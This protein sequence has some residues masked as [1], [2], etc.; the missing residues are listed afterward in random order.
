[1]E[2]VVTTKRRHIYPPSKPGTPCT[3]FWVGP[4]AVLG[5]GLKARPPPGFYPQA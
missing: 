4:M 5:E 2:W 1:M 3:G